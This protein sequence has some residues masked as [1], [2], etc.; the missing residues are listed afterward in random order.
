MAIYLKHPEL[1]GNVTHEK[2]KDHIEFSLAEWEVG[3]STDMRAGHYTDVKMSTPWASDI[4][5]I[6]RID[7]A[8]PRIMEHIRKD[9]VAQDVKLFY[10]SDDREI[11]VVTLNDARLNYHK[12]TMSEGEIRE[13]IQINYSEIRVKYNKYD[14]TGKL[15]TSDEGVFDIAKLTTTA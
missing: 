13:Q 1:K 6:K 15:V 11:L 4:S 8:T 9:K 5:L 12:F 14:K 7:L 10:V 3:C 2:Y